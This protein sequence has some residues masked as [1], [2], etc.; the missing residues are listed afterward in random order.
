MSIKIKNSET[1]LFIG[2]SITDCYRREMSRPLG[3][4]YVNF[5]SD[6]L[7][8]REPA[9]KI[10]IINKGI[11]GNTI[12]N[13][14]ERWS[15]DVLINKPDW[16]SIKIGINDLHRYLM[17]TEQSV[18]SEQFLEIYDQLL[19]ITRKKLP[20]CKV[21]LVEPFYLST[22]TSNI[23]MRKE[24]LDLL[25]EYSQTVKKMSRKYKTKLV[26]TQDL[27]LKILKY[28]Q[29][30]LLGAEPVHPYPIGHLMIAEWIYSALSQ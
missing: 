18:S 12:R 27:F 22:E 17:K 1:I 3:N 5:F 9:K 20:K 28:H 6:L 29:P 10:N 14:R 16:L 8:M 26:K 4:G 30:D 13:L 19:S 25:P 11:S 2:D 24:V 23:S 15:D 7:T 21:I